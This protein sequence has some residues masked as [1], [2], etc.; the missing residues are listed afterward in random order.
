MCVD[1]EACGNDTR[2]NFTIIHEAGRSQFDMKVIPD[3]LENKTVIQDTYLMIGGT[4]FKVKSRSSKDW[5]EHHAD[6]YATF[7]LIPKKFVSK[8]TIILSFKNKAIKASKKCK[9]YVK[10]PISIV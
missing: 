6:K 1:L 10:Q 8:S 3:V 2:A 5:M 4:L 9:N 7:I